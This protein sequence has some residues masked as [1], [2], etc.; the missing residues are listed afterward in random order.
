MNNQPLLEVRNLWKSF[1]HKEYQIEILKGIDL[2]IFKGNT[3][4]ITRT[5]FN[6]LLMHW[7]D[8]ATKNWD[9]F[10]NFIIYYLNLLLGKM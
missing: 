10:F 3:I 8:F 6:F 2:K 1:S 7:L 4:A 9:L 5:Y